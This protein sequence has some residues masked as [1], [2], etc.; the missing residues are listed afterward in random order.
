MSESFSTVDLPSPA[1]VRHPSPPGFS[2]Y[3]FD[4]DSFPRASPAPARSPTPTI[5]INP[6]PRVTPAMAVYLM[7]CGSSF[8]A[9]LAWTPASA[10]SAPPLPSASNRTPLA[11]R[12]AGWSFELDTMPLSESAFQAVGMFVYMGN[13]CIHDLLA[14]TVAEMSGCRGVT[15]VCDLAIPLVAWFPA[16]YGQRYPDF[17]DI[18]PARLLHERLVGLL[19]RSIR[20]NW[21]NVGQREHGLSARQISRARTARR[22]YQCERAARLEE[23]CVELVNWFL[24]GMRDPL[25]GLLDPE[26]HLCFQ[27]VH[28]GP[29][30]ACMAAVAG[31]GLD[32]NDF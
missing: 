14:R 13:C 11:A 17:V 25:D 2:P 28:D 7:A 16:L 5:P 30:E 21:V 6:Y 12:I 29:V 26:D 24:G 19:N 23:R 3:H 18:N 15:I 4:A 32:W 8:C 9:H 10:L 20:G 22:R 31:L 27:Q 1:T